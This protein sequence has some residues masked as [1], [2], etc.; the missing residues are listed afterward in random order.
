MTLMN[1]PFPAYV[2]S[3]YMPSC[4]VVGILRWTEK[5]WK[6]IRISID[7]YW[8]LTI[9]MYRVRPSTPLVEHM[10]DRERFIEKVFETPIKQ[11]MVSQDIQACL[12]GWGRDER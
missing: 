3:S 12:K 4:Y 5:Q 9:G 11:M 8:G 10:M 7:T 1:M 2:R 6:V